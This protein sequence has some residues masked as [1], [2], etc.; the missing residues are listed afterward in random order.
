MGTIQR[1]FTPIRIRS[2]SLPGVRFFF[3]LPPRFTPFFECP[4]LQILLPKAAPLILRHLQTDAAKRLA[5]PRAL[6]SSRNVQT[7]DGAFGA[8][9]Q[10]KLP[11]NLDDMSRQQTALAV[12]CR[13]L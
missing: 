13:L 9:K 6:N 7:T 5:L 10:P 2:V 4:L 11:F 12:N 3:V 8:A 1:C